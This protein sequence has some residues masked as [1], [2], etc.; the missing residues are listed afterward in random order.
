MR[1][2]ESPFSS[3]KLYINLHLLFIIRHVAH[4][5][6]DSLTHDA[7]TFQGYSRSIVYDRLKPSTI[8]QWNWFLKTNRFDIGGQLFDYSRLCYLRFMSQIKK[9]SLSRGTSNHDS[10]KQQYIY[11]YMWDKRGTLTNRFYLLFEY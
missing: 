9:I 3:I 8:M 10:V 4:L 1:E 7:F 5:E 2:S 6:S 11:I